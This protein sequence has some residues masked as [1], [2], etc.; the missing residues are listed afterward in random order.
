MPEI[1]EGVKQIR[2]GGNVI[3][4]LRLESRR[5]PG[6]ERNHLLCPHEGLAGGREF[7]GT[8][9]ID[10]PG[11]QTRRAPAFLGRV[12]AGRCC[13]EKADRNQSK[14]WEGK[15]KIR[16]EEKSNHERQPEKQGRLLRV[17]NRQEGIKQ[18]GLE[19]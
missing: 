17:L 7:A 13:R 3:R 5:V 12:S 18:K 19:K 1:L 11:A 4:V 8:G 10:G 6:G 15:R 14:K 2:R 16:E 9:G